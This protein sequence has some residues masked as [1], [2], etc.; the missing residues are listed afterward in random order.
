MDHCTTELINKNKKYKYNI[1]LKKANLAYWKVVVKS[2]EDDFI[3]Y[4]FIVYIKYLKA[5]FNDFTF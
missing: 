1:K 3:V 2:L 4:D 5:L